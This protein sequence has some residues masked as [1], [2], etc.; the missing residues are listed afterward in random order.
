[1]KKGILINV[2]TQ[3]VNYVVLGNDYREIYPLINA[4]LFDVIRINRSND[5]YVDD[6]GLLTLTEESK[7]FLIKGYP[8]PIA[9]SGLILGHNDEGESISTDLTIEQVIT[10]ITFLDMLDVINYLQIKGND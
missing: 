5:L 7:F 9:G 2:N 1:M 10:T 3:Q 6:E 4:H 8:Q